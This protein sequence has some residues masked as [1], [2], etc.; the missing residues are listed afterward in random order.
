MSVTALAAAAAL[1]LGTGH[2]DGHGATPGTP[3]P[4]PTTPPAGPTVTMEGNAFLP[5][6]VVALVGEDVA[7]S[8]TDGRNHD[9]AGDGFD[10]GLLAPGAVYTHAFEDQ[11]TYRY[12]CTIHRFMS[13]TVQ[14]FGLAFESAT[15]AVVPG[16]RVRV[17]GRAPKG[18]ALVTIERRA[19]GGVFVPAAQV[20]PGAEGAF[21][22]R[23]RIDAAGAYRARTE[24][25]T[26]PAVSIRLV[27]MVH[28]H[29]HRMGAAVHVAATVA[30]ATPG[31]RAVL[32]RYVRELFTWRSIARAP[33]TRAGTASFELQA[34]DEVYLR[35]LVTRA[36]GGFADAASRSVRIPALRP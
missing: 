24:S 34:R 19:A 20:A 3:M 26:S 21:S 13:G 16:G 28:A 18:T 17:S 29:A 22:A 12:R 25:L 30:P 5:R 23:L 9:I 33:V 35:V 4:E 6:D 32:Q 14:V 7:W 10:S 8:N 2:D 11:G 36:R 27:P 31:A 15:S 1:L